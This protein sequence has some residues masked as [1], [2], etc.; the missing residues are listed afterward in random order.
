MSTIA[1]ML[2][3]MELCRMR[4]LMTLDEIAKLPNPQAVLGWRPGP[5]RAHI[6]WQLTHIGITE[7][8]TS[9][10]RMQGTSP[11]YS[12]LV[13]RFKFGS[14]PDDDIPAVDL[15]RQVLSESRQ[16]IRDCFAKISES[17]L[18]TIPEWYKER[19]WNIRRILQILVW[20]EA[21]H[22]GQAHITLN[23]WKAA[24]PKA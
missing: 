22:Q 16:H 5:G 20:H 12:D 8:L 17:D 6:G 3:A 19:G 11:A 1:I 7:E 4:T 13:P 14:T 15:I 2:D 10:E 23:L 18:D 24:Q 9:T 21:H